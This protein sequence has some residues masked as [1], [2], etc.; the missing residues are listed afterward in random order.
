[1]SDLPLRS[2]FI[3]DFRRLEGHRVLP[4]DAPIILLHGQNG[5]GKTSVLS[6]LEL[7]LTGEIRSMRR[8]DPRYMAHLPFHGQEFATLR[9]EVSEQLSARR[10][11]D[12]M[13]V[14][15]SRIDGAPALDA[16]AAQFYAERCYLDQVSLGQLLELYQYREGKEE[17]ALARF[18]NELL[19]LEQLDALR[20]GLSDAN[21]FR[22]L[23]KLSEPLADAEAKAR[24]ANKDLSRATKEL[25]SARTAAAR[26]REGLEQA[27]GTLGLAMPEADDQQWGRLVAARLR[28]SR[29]DDDH[30]AVVD[31]NRSVTLL[32]GRIEGL[33]DRPSLKRLEEARS[34]VATASAELERWRAQHEEAIEAWRSDA[35]ELELHVSGE[36]TAPIDDE[37]QAIDESIAR[38]DE[39]VA[40][41]AQLSE[42]L[43]DAQTSLRHVQTRLTAAQQQA[44]SLAEGLASLREHS[45]N[46]F[47]PVC[48]R[49]FS[50]VSSTPLMAHID[51]KIE[52]LTS[53]GKRLRELR[54]QRDADEA[55]VMRIE[56]ELN[57]IVGELLSDTRRESASTRRAA[58]VSLRERLV[59]LQPKILTGVDLR[60]QVRAAE[61]DLERLESVAHEAS[62]ARTRLEE[63]A[64]AL[65]APPPDGAQGL[66]D[67]WRQLADATAERLERTEM[68][69]QA[70]SSAVRLLK[71]TLELEE[72]VQGLEATV[73]HAAERKVAWEDRVQEARRRQAVAR[74]VHDASSKARAAIVQ[75]V[76]TRSLNEVWQSVFTRLAPREPFVPA[77]GVPTSSKTALEIT[78][79]TVH[80]SGESGGSPQMML[81]AGNLNTAALSLF[82]A[83]H[84]AV[85][86]LVPCLVFDDPVQSMD[87]VHVSQ[88]AGLIRVLAKHHRRQV[89]IAVHERELFEYLALELS[90]AFEGDELIT[91]ELGSRL[92]DEVR[93]VTRFTWSQDSA[94]A[95]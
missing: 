31:L 43:S 20:S 70:H 7:A 46:N 95:L 9:V 15:G 92:D 59:R 62:S 74:A 30:A 54:V 37:L 44:G 2:I 12:T 76:F 3:S 61:T 11:P 40:R 21:D 1:M 72:R 32:G 49:D 57:E 63:L 89:V 91:I 86:P 60:A 39:L 82:I 36:D 14:G 25:D 68:R 94:I 41:R 81:S 78:L 16:E 42:Q 58:L 33:A 10:E 35:A 47:C 34:K 22:R 8:Q 90:P 55:E 18:V 28:S 65:D 24:Q 87:E 26:S 5:T 23:K 19:G 93:G 67:V 6:A 69:R 50:E 66:Q 51:E 88:F 56:R 17:S 75:R 4:L 45:S 85:E 83:L 71:E 13:T 52:E 29:P 80:S 48:D 73:T 27:L 38:D 79:E 64:Q 84:L 77:F 53:Q